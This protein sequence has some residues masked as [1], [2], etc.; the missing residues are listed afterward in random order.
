MVLLHAVLVLTLRL[1]VSEQALQ[2]L[3]H[4]WGWQFLR[5][6]FKHDVLQI[7]HASSMLR[8]VA[9]RFPWKLSR[10][11]F[12]MRAG[13]LRVFV[14]RRGC[15]LVRSAL[16]LACVCFSATALLDLASLA[17]Q[18]ALLLLLPPSAHCKLSRCFWKQ[19]TASIPGMSAQTHACRERSPRNT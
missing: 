10:F 8:Q 11:T 17:K 5:I 1:R 9:R 16:P 4:H 18:L 2:L 7:W 12:S 19:F 3:A 6:C 14:S 15:R 13:F